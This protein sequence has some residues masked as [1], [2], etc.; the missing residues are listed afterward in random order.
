MTK[1]KN[2]TTECDE[3]CGNMDDSIQLSRYGCTYEWIRPNSHQRYDQTSQ[4]TNTTTI[5]KIS[6]DDTSYLIRLC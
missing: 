4:K 3:D 5:Q 2:K 1:F 6:I